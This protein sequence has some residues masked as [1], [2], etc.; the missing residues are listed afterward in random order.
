MKKFAPKKANFF[1]YPVNKIVLTEQF[2]IFL[3]ARQ[4]IYSN[5]TVPPNQII[6]QIPL[7]HLSEACVYSNAGGIPARIFHTSRSR[8]LFRSAL[9]VRYDSNSRYSS[10]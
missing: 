10:C 6:F 4:W 1:K 7:Q 2:I 9:Y 3:V 5:K 8:M